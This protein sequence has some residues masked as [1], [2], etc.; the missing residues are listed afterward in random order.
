MTTTTTGASRHWI[1]VLI[2]SVF[3]WTM[4][5]LDQSLFGYA[6]PGILG[7]FQVGLD[8]VGLIL[9]VGFITASV[10]VIFAGLAA[11]TWGRRWTLTA[12][13]ALSALF[14]GLHGLVED[15]AQL[16][17]LRA[18]AFGLAAGLAPITAAYVA[19][20]APARHRGM[21][22]GVL[23]CG[24]PLGWFLAAMLAA[25]LLE[26]SGW[27]SIF[28]IGF[29]VVPIAFLIGWRLPESERFQ[30]VAATRSSERASIIDWGLLREMFSIDYRRRSIA[31]IAL[32][33]AFGC[34]YAGTAFF[35]PTYFMEVRGYS[36][37]EA[38]QLVGLSNGIAIFGY[39]AA[40]YVGEYWLPRRDTFA[41]WTLLGAAALVAL[42][43]LP[44]ERWQDLA[45][46]GLTGA[47]F[48]GSNAVVGALL[49]DL[50]PTRMRTTAYA[51]CGSAP[52]SAGFALFPALVPL[53]VQSAGWQWSFT[54]MI[55]PLLVLAALAALALPRI[56]SGSD[57][58][59][60]NR[61]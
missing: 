24:Y 34:A 7:E 37:S 38:A 46:F 31:S 2:F 16:T 55:A 26:T 53:V 6:I 23:Q 5:N 35:F 40:A 17:W 3:A 29:A 41:L 4:S 18:L 44:Q 39:L 58:D 43:W 48:Y 22:M 10:M 60:V 12:L 19:E 27:R 8:V 15:L 45:L 56:A 13:L 21:L 59:A 52:L 54:V 30:Q 28:F 57:I 20:S 11:D 42:M 33:F 9:T 47:F 36:Q 50:F 51:V 49:T 32:F 25:P 1:S 61:G 14:V